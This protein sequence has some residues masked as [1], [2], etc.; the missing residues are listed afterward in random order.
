MRRFTITFVSAICLL[1]ACTSKEGKRQTNREANPKPFIFNMNLLFTDAENYVSFPIWF[2]DSVIRSAHVS[3][4]SR[5]IIG[6]SVNDDNTKS[7]APHEIR[8]YYF[9]VSGFI[10]SMIVRYFFDDDFIGK[11]N[12]IFT[13]K[14]DYFGFANSQQWMILNVANSAQDV[15]LDPLFKRH[16]K[17]KQSKKAVSFVEIGNSSHLHCML[18]KKYWGPLSVDSIVHPNKTDLIVL[19]TMRKPLKKY[20]VLNTV[21]EQNVQQFAYYKKSFSP[22]TI[23][24]DEYPFLVERTFQYLKNGICNGFTDSTF[25]KKNFLATTKTHFE[26]GKNYFPIKVTKTRENSGSSKVIVGL[27]KFEYYTYD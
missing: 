1:A 18:T 7:D 5:E 6:S 2:N 3:K 26:F 12:V 13:S 22:K 17:I 9:N 19:G 11:V 16:V 8:D 25:S 14:P 24:R 23:T 21:N 27:E 4:I 10:D 20:S 15:T